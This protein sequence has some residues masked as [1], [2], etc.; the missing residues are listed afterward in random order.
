M[1][2][3]KEILNEDMLNM[4]DIITV[5]GGGLWIKRH[6]KKKATNEWIVT[7]NGMTLMEKGRKQRRRTNEKS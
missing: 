7:L 6:R 5:E 1:Q 4:V 3:G 2:N